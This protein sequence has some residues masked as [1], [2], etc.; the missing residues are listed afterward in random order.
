MYLGVRLAIRLQNTFNV[1]MTHLIE[2]ENEIEFANIF[3]SSVKRFHKNLLDVIINYATRD[4][5][6]CGPGLNQEYRVHSRR[7]L[8]RKRNGE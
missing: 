1:E 3:E 6:S 7:H 4:Q 8:R 5:T 2:M